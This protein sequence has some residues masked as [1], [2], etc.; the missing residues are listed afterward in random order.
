M[1]KEVQKGY[2]VPATLIPLNNNFEFPVADM[3]DIAGGYH[4]VKKLDDM[5]YIPR[6]HRRIGMMC[7]VIDEDDEYRL[8]INS[9]TN[10]TSLANWVKIDRSTGSTGSPIGSLDLSKYV[11]KTMFEPVKE[12]V[13]NLPDFSLY[14]T[15]VDVQITKNNTMDYV[16]QALVN[17]A[18]M[19]DIPDVSS[20]LNETQVINLIVNSHNDDDVTDLEMD[21]LFV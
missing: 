15:K 13:E 1:S 14:A 19:T 2:R 16:D 8:I 11:T 3:E 5:F 6:L 7:Y 12:V 18:H 21:S 9:G 17:V 10:K 4:V 20:F